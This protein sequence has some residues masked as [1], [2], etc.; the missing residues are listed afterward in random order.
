MTKIVLISD[1]HGR[2]EELGVLPEGN[3]LIHAGDC[4]NDIGRKSLREFLIWFNAQ[5]HAH[6][7]LVAG[8]HDGAFEKWP[9]LAKAM[10]KEFAPS[11]HYLQDEQIVID[12]IKIWGSPVQPEFLN[13]HFNRQRGAEIKR[14][15]DMIPD[16]TDILITHGPAHGHLD[17]LT[18]DCFGN[19]ANDRAGCKDLRETIDSRLKKL[20]LHVFGHLHYQGGKYKIENNI[21]YVNAAVVNDGYIV[22][23]K[24]IVVE[25]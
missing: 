2:H 8:N 13:W 15:W 16:N 7:L 23:Q 5:S 6:K 19:G 1:T 4:T 14:H 25:I 22:C 11:V 10:V 12:G 18:P 20:K 21:T 17:L 9:D 3:I 24:P